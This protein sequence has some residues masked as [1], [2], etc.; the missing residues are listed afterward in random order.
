MRSI[1]AF[2]GNY[3]WITALVLLVFI[4]SCSSEP[5]RPNIILILSDDQA[6]GDAE[7]SGNDILETPNLNS[8][9]LEGAQFDNFYVSPMCAPSRASLMTG[10]YNLRT[11]T[12]WVGRRSELLGLNE[13]TLADILKE[14]GYATGIYGKWHLGEYGPYHPN[15]RGF[16]DFTGFSLGAANNYFNTKLEHNGEKFTSDAYITDVLTDSA[17]CFIEKHKGEPFFCYIPYNVPHHPFQ[18]PDPYFDKYKDKGVEDNRT[19]SV[20]GMVDNMDKNI[21]RILQQLE[22]LELEEN[23]IIIFLSDNGPAYKR[24]N[25]GLSGIKAQVGEGSV[26][27]P[28]YIMWKDHIPQGLKLNELAAHID[29]LPTLLDA[30]GITVPDSLNIDGESLLPM[31]SGNKKEY[32]QRSIYAHQTVFGE[33]FATPG[34]LRT[35]RYRLQNWKNG[36]ELFD[37]LNDPT[38]K[39]DISAEEPELYKRLIADYENWYGDVTSAG[40]NWPPVP[41]GY[42]DYDTTVI[43]APDALK[44]DGINYSG[45]RGWATDWFCDWKS[46]ADSVT[47]Q[48]DVYEAGK[49]EFILHYWCKKENTG[50]EFSLGNVDSS[51]SAIL[52][53]PNE[54][55]FHELPN[56]TPE[57]APLERDWAKLSLGEMHLQAGKQ[58]LVLKATS[59]PG[60]N[61]GE[62][63]SLEVIRKKL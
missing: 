27:V 1:E 45:K 19:A 47:W 22:E 35:E 59:I 11:G 25:D 7:L 44:S 38:Q 18:V 14:E 42:S 13:T 5:E 50:S 32:P 43:I 21:G 60:E 55:E 57:G 23:T 24:Y 3:S 63:R 48:I 62:F 52:A 6:W 41:V 40:T 46:T 37:M 49:Y 34:G 4:Q 30:A 54:S 51:V 15:E 10:R 26:K 28:F 58:D 9:A 8:I 2:W 20:Y 56:K 29:L 53:V 61:A 33:C 39:T 31:L 16:D 36:Y 12:S 17:M